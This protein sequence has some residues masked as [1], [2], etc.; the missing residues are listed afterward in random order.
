MLVCFRYKKKQTK[1]VS[2]NLTSCSTTRD[3][4]QWLLSFE[5]LAHLASCFEDTAI[6]G[7][8]LLQMDKDASLEAS[9]V[10]DGVERAHL[11]LLI[12]RARRSEKRVRHPL[13]LIE[14]EEMVP[15]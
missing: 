10:E 9:G 14:M 4:V 5:D 2:R 13:A 8:I 6:T 1:K 15:A 3:V 7:Q 11:L 12:R